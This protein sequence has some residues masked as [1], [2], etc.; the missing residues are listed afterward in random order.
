MYTLSLG[1]MADLTLRAFAYLRLPLA[2]AGVAFVVGAAGAWRQPD[3]GGRRCQW[4][5]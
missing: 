4:R 2:V 3:V 1:H 5:H